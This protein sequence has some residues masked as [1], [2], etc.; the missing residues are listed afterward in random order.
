MVRAQRDSIRLLQ[1]AL[2]AAIALP[3]ALFLYAAW[4]GYDSAQDVADRQIERT[5]DAINEHALKVFEAVERTVAEINEIIRGMS[6]AEITA[7]QSPLHERL[8][9]LAD[10]S[11]QIK[12]VWIFDRHGHA[13][14]NSLAFPVD[15]TD[16]SDRDYFKAHIDHDIG[17]F[18]GAV[19]R[20]RPPYGGA[21][22]FG[23]S[24]RRTSPDGAFTG[25]IQASILPEYFEG[26]Y[27]KLAREPGAYASLARQDGL[28][29]ARY[30][31][32]GREVR[33]APQ[34]ALM[35]SMRI[36]PVAG[37][38]SLIST[39]D[40]TGRKVAYRKL[41]EFPVYVLAGLETAA[42]RNQWLS[43]LG[44]QLIFG[45]PA[46]AALIGIVALALRRTRRLYAEAA[47]RQSAEEALKQSQRLEALGQLTG[48]VAHDFNNLLMVI[49]QRR[50]AEVTHQR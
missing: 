31:S 47:G 34:A 6:D 41:D 21:P 50:A 48:G 3:L 10:G 16:F 7:E 22:F 39:I 20:P 26:F 8:Q 19:L 28:I 29:L 43:Q 1:G 17:T 9:R 32:L 45:L 13:L 42:I 35:Q 33:L 36:H 24:R 5:T 4:L 14:V 38:V 37:Q 11:S 40:R 30:P 44:S 49:G 2:V 25:V 18:V 12:S 27:A 46:T 23:V 15:T